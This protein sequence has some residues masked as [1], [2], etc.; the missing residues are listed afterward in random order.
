MS[1]VRPHLRLAI[2]EVC[3]RRLLP[4][5]LL[6]AAAF[7][8]PGC[9][10]IVHGPRQTVTVT[11][12]PTGAAITVLSGQTVKATPGVTP[13]ELRLP[14]KDGSMTLRLEKPGC[15]PAEVRLKRGVS[16]WTFVNLIAANPFAMQGYDR[17]AAG[18][19]AKQ[20]LIAIPALF[21]V[22]VISGGAYKLPKV[23]DVRLCS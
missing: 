4:A 3:M 10:T 8:T 18:Q 22:D 23:I 14:R 16:G 12:D 9:A 2:R 20:L 21:A 1:R 15:A 17:D 19:Y 13:L 11:S 5:G 7:G 6:C